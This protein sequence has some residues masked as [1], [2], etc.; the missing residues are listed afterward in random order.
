[1]TESRRKQQLGVEI[2]GQAEQSAGD[3]AGAAATAV[4]NLRAKSDDLLLGLGAGLG[5]AV[6]GTLTLGGGG[7][8][9]RRPGVRARGGQ[10]RW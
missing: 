3:R 1:M 2:A 6:F 7:V 8:V 4:R 5:Q 9:R 10:Q